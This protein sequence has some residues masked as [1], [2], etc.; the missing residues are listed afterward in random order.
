MT[1]LCRLVLIAVVL[2]VA[3]CGGPQ[4]RLHHTVLENPEKALPKKVVVLPADI[5]V[6]ELTAGGVVE[7]VPEWSDQAKKSIM[8]ALIDFAAKDSKFDYVEMPELNKEQQ[9]QLDLQLAF[10]DVVGGT[11]YGTTANPGKAWEHK[12]AHF[13][14]SIGDGLKFIKEQSGAD[15]GIIVSA[16]DFVPTAERKAMA[17][18]MA[19]LGVAVWMGNPFLFVGIV[20][21]ET[22]NILWMNF[23]VNGGF[24]DLRDQKDA[25]SMLADIFKLYPGVEKYKVAGK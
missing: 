22:G 16:V 21:F 10:Y 15:A 5:K 25:A 2:L 12:L 19:A 11:A 3:A 20:D 6:N 23:A 9:E 8:A 1:R 7:E 17:V 4:H 24:S 14:Y 18:G 13:D